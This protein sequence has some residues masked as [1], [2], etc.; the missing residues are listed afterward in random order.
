[1][2]PSRMV[3]IGP[4]FLSQVPTSRASV[5][6]F[7]RLASFGKKTLTKA[8]RMRASAFRVILLSV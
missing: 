2:I 5:G 8:L 4:G 1:M 3:V 6:R 7:G